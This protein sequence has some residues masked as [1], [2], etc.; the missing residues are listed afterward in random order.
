MTS[1]SPRGEGYQAYLVRLWQER[2]DT[3][4]R[5]LV[6]D[7]AND[8]EHRFATIE[9]LFLFLRRQT[10]GGEPHGAEVIVS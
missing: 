4:W 9:D 2:P 10:D 7:A 8:E 5:A 1:N 3:P 6:R